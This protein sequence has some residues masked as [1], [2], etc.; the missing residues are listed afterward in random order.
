[1][2][3]DLGRPTIYDVVPTLLAAM[4]AAL[5]ADSD[6]RV[7]FEAFE[8]EFG[9]ALDVHEA[10]VEL[11]RRSGADGPHGSKEVESRLKALGYL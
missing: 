4:G 5:P 1:M 7:L 11:E 8:P 10:Q 2:P 9:A 3:G 6:G